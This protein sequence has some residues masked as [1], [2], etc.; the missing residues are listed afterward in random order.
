M[1]QLI[2]PGIVGR[3]SAAAPMQFSP[4]MAAVRESLTGKGSVAKISLETADVGAIQGQAL[5]D[6]QLCCG[7]S[8]NLSR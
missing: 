8:G 7:L 6:G 5:K 4:Q 3:I 2:V 1:R